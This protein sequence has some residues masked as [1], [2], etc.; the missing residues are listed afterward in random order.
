M[1]N[2]VTLVW[3]SLRLAQIMHRHYLLTFEHTA[4]YSSSAIISTTSGIYINRYWFSVN[5][6]SHLLPGTGD[7]AVQCTV[8]NLQQK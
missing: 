6:C 4:Y 5:I 1:C 8:T 3:D 7:I 2:E